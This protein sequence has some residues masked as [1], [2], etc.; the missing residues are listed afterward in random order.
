MRT[1]WVIVHT[2]VRALS[3]TEQVL[4]KMVARLNGQRRRGWLEAF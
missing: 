1:E 3:G 2:V 4:N